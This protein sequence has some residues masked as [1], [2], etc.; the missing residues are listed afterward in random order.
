M[1]LADRAKTPQHQCN[2][3]APDPAISIFEG[4]QCFEFNMRQ[5]RS[6][7]GD[8]LGRVYKSKQL[9]HPCLKGLGRCRNEVYGC[10]SAALTDKILLGLIGP[11]PLQRAATKHQKRLVGVPDQ[12]V[13]KGRATPQRILRL[14]QRP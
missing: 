2:Q 3:H 4:M 14:R 10:G 7:N 13:G 9:I 6:Q 5:R 12:P 1:W 8:W 11:G